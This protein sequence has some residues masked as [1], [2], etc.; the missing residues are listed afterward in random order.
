MDSIKSNLEWLMNHKMAIGY[1]FIALF[2]IVL[3]QQLYNRYIKSSNHA[4]YYEGYS[5]APN[6]G[7]SDPPVATI[8]IFTVEWCPH[9]K[10]AK[11]EIE[12]IQKK[13]E[14]KIINGHKLHFEV[15]DGDSNEDLVNKY[16]IAG[17]PTVIL[18]KSDDEDKPIELD[19]KTDED[20]L[21]KFMNAMI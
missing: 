18:T 4:S 16:K 2:F 15:I 1:A 14:G 10:K 12:N 21:L 5:N 17:F 11:P 20:T 13:Y 19:G 9:C 6:S 8:R 3:A 7:T